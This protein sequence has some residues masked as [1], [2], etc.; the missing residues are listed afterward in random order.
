[1]CRTPVATTVDAE[2]GHR[3]AG[4]SNEETLMSRALETLGRFAARRPWLVI[5]T[6]V[7]VGVLVVT[8]AVAFG[9]ELEDPFEAPG[10]DSHR[11]TELLAR[12]GLDRGGLGADV[13][14]TPQDPG[15]RS[16]TPPRRRPRWRGSSPPWRLC[17]RSSPRPIRRVPWSPGGRPPSSPVSSRP[18]ADR[19]DPG[20]VPRARATWDRGPGGAQDA[21]GRPPRH[22]VTAD[23]GRRRPV[24]RFRGAPS[25]RR[26]GARPARRDRDPAPGIR[27]GGR[28]GS[29][30]RHGPA[31]ARG[32]RPARCH[33]SRTSST[34]RPGRL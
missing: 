20:P 29:A 27:V 1:M 6:W 11:A 13:V 2:V 30:D 8:S 18:T 5:G 17:R 31:R 19:T 26:R 9:R 22:V 33:S 32:R 3:P 15:R 10:L 21:P 14:V 23:R 28:D 16:S 34:S 4:R 24:L 12:R 25:G 7:I